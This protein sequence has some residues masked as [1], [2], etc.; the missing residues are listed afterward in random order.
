M[1]RQNAAL[2]R[3]AD[4]TWHIDFDTFESRISERTR[5]FILCNPHNPTGRA[6]RRDEL[7]RI[8]E[9]CLRRGVLICS[10]EI[11]CDILF[12]GTRHIPIASLDPEI[13][14]RTVTLIAPSKT[15]NIPGLH[16]S[17]AVVAD[18]DLRRQ[19]Q[20]PEPA[21]FPEVNALGFTAALAAYRH[22]GEWLQQ[23]LLYLE[24]NRNLVWDYVFRELPGIE[25]CKPEATYLAWLDCRRAGI[26]GD[27]YRFF[28][29]KAR[30]ALSAGSSFGKPGEGFV[31]LNFACPR[32]TLLEAL[33]RMK[34]ALEVQQGLQGSGE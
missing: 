25:M 10:D 26:S 13:G 18:P 17:M 6:F 11:H 27:P 2:E 4:G 31:R 19:M 33:G 9:I 22:G 8:A 12:A 3:G 24:A 20:K 5:V 7:E 16:C 14:R 15:F 1:E 30:V 21:F 28:L 29:E 34:A 32:S 23:A